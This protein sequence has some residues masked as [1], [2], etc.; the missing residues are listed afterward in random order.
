MAYFYRAS[1]YETLGNDSKAQP[2]YEKALRLNPSYAN[3][4]K[5]QIR[6]F[7]RIVNERAETVRVCVRPI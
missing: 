6:P 1:A 7:L 4:V 5:T 3:K 2:D